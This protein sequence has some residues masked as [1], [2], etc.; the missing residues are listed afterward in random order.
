ME[1]HIMM[2]TYAYYD[3]YASIE[4]SR[5]ETYFTLLSEISIANVSLFLKI[6]QCK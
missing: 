4:T 6:K 1:M 2:L 3:A 5:S